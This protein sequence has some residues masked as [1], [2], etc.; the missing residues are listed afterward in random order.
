MYIIMIYVMQIWR[1][2]TWFSSDFQQLRLELSPCPVLHD[3]HILVNVAGVARRGEVHGATGA[4]GL[5][6]A[7]GHAREA[8]WAQKRHQMTLHGLRFHGC[9]MDAPWML[10]VF[11]N[12]SSVTWLT[13][14]AKA[15]SKVIQPIKRITIA[16]FRLMA[17]TGTEHKT[18]TFKQS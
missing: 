6:E 5:L 12:V 3:L 7:Q 2:F 15:R 18:H 17:V 4:A 1:D 9:S 11:C 14:V 13:L 8:P 10:H 16:S